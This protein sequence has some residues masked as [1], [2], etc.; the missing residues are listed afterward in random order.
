MKRFNPSNCY[1]FFCGKPADKDRRLIASPT[2]AFICDRCVS[3]CQDKLDLESEE[4]TPIALG[5]VPT[6]KEFKEYLDQYVVG[7]DDAKKV[8]SL[9]FTII[10][11]VF[12]HRILQI[13][14]TIKSKLKNQTFFS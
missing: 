7:Q 13:L 12:Q 3:A 4:L 5:D 2:G 10:T 8:L 11:N 14:M 6:P 1:C 9:L